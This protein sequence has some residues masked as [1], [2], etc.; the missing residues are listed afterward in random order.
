MCYFG[1]NLSCAIQSLM[2]APGWRPSFKFYHWTLSMT[3]ALLCL[4]IMFISA[5][6]FAIIA[7]LIGAVVYKYIEY[8]GA[9]KEWGDGLKGLKL[10]AARYALLNVDARHE[11]HSRNWRPQLLVL[12]PNKQVFQVSERMEQQQDR[13]LSFVSQLKVGLS[14]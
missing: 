5:W 14:S 13:L 7:I 4:M 3:G 9:E 12:Y 8:A 10:S 11:Q 1:I 6:H 2:R